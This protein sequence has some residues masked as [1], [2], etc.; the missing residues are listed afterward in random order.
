M[1]KRE[2]LRPELLADMPRRIAG[3]HVDRRGYPIPWFVLDNGGEPDFRIVDSNKLRHALRFARC[4]ICGGPLGVNKTF[5]V[6]PMCV[7][8][9]V[10]AEPPTHGDCGV[11]AARFCPFLAHPQAKRR[12][13][14]LPEHLP[15]DDVMLLHNPG[16][17]A[18]WTTRRFTTFRHNGALLCRFGEPVAVQWFAEG[19]RASRDE[20]VAGFHR[21]LPGLLAIDKDWTEAEAFAVLAPHLPSEGHEHATDSNYGNDHSVTATPPS[22]DVPVAVPH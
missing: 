5:V 9:R 12:E 1:S 10:S 13:A 18:V 17:V 21:G 8:T 7:V 4:W 20:V 6:G 2:C 16:A 22:G 11:F 19:R 15:A 14:N 3:L